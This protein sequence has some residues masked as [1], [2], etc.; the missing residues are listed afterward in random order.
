MTEG[1]VE[2]TFDD[3][4]TVYSHSSGAPSSSASNTR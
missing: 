4:P 2:R 3:R 1:W